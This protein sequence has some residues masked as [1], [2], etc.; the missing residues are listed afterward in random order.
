MTKTDPAAIEQAYAEAARLFQSGRPAEAEARLKPWLDRDVPDGRLHGLAGFIRVRSG[1]PLSAIPALRRARELVPQEPVFALALGDALLAC[2]QAVEAQAAYRA[3]LTLDPARIPA[4]VGLAKALFTQGREAAALAELTQ[5]IARGERDLTL[6]FTCAEMQAA[7]GLSDDAIATWELSVRSHPKS[8]VAWH[9]LA[10]AYG[11]VA[12][13]ADSESAAR[14]A[15]AMGQQ[16]PPTLLVLARALQG[17]G[18]LD[19]AETA[20]RD[21]LRAAPTSVDPNRDLAQLVWMRTGDVKAAGASLRT[22]LS[23]AP[24]D[25]GLNQTLAKLHQFA[26]DADGARRILTDAVAAAAEPDINLLFQTADLLLAQGDAD[27]G[28]A[29]AERA[30]KLAP[31]SERM[32][33]TLADCLLGVGDGARA[34]EICEGLLQRDPDDQVVLARLATA[35]RLTGDERYHQLYDYPRYVRPYAIEAP[36]GWS[37][38]PDYLTDLSQALV[39]MHGFATHPFDQSLRNGSQTSENLERSDHP[40]IRAFFKAIDAPIRAHMEHL[41]SDTSGLG[42]RYLGDYVLSGTWSVY[43]RPSGFHVDHVHPMGWLSSA[44]YVETP[45]SPPEDPH[46]GWIKFGEPGNPTRPKLG[47]EHHVQPKPG[48]LVLFPS[49]M[50]HG[51]VPFTSDERRLTIAFDVRPRAPR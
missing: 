22:A 5:R 13:F 27:A 37:N 28:L 36:A 51:T 35:W 49:Y 20:F 3:A 14:R 38:V 39:A 10:A 11:D 24:G 7:A 21:V 34:A 32:L 30:Q 33:I 18:R 6:L 16:S 50:W 17:L 26:G 48:T 41:R 1:A 4:V 45:A 47:P 15:I 19:V 29:L 46:A 43:L 31:N 25:P 9:N 23:L 40:A 42:R 44:F 8:G 2:D 12:R